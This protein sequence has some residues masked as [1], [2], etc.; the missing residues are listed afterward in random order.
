[1]PRDEEG[2]PIIPHEAVA[3]VECDGYLAVN[4][5]GDQAE[6]TCNECGVVVRTVAADQVAGAMVTLSLGV[7]CTARCP[8]CDAVNLFPG[9]SSVD[10]FVCKECGSDV[11]V[12]RPVQ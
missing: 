9:F 1:M 11:T 6:I 10:A 4:V 8:H 3:D 12:E 2:Y 5:S 7:F